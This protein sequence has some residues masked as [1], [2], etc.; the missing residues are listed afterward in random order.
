M[1]II[2]ISNVDILGIGQTTEGALIKAPFDIPN[3]SVPWVCKA[4]HQYMQQGRRL[5]VVITER[6]TPL[7]SSDSTHHPYLAE[8]NPLFLLLEDFVCVLTLHSSEVYVW[9][10]SNHTFSQPWGPCLIFLVLTHSKY[11]TTFCWAIEHIPLLRVT[12]LTMR[13]IQLIGG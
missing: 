12:W 3:H 4:Q 5:G 7:F 11:S 10:L 1:T 9:V 8:V 6:W 13:M 2:K